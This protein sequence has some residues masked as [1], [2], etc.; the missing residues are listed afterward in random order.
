M[1][2][3]AGQFSGARKTGLGGR[4]AGAEGIAREERLLRVLGRRREGLWRLGDDRETG[5]GDGGLD[6]VGAELPH[7]AGI[8]GVA[9]VVVGG[10]FE[11]GVQGEADDGRSEDGQKKQRKDP[12]KHRPSLPRSPRFG[13][14]ASGM[15]DPGFSRAR[16][17][18]DNDAVRSSGHHD[19]RPVEIRMRESRA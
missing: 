19:R 1:T 9:V 6:T 7:V 4:S 13:R 15:T 3:Q 5:I 12:P 17:L 8:I 16:V 10:R 2:G 18:D 11:L 14:M